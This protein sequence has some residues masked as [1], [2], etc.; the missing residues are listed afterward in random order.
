MTAAR[1]PPREPRPNAMAGRTVFVVLIALGLGLL[2]LKYGFDDSSSGSSS[3]A[4]TTTSSSTTVAD[5]STTTTIDLTTTQVLVAN[6]SGVSG[7]AARVSAGLKDKGYNVLPPT[8]A[9]Q[10]GLPTS[11]VYYQPGYEAQA[12]Q[13][14][15]SLGATT[16]AAM[17]SPP[18][19]AALG[20]ADVLVV[21]GKDLAGTPTG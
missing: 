20:E 5:A 21:V 1:R 11:T 6:G 18:P 16:T 12:G 7:A 14:A 15:Q 4:T 13:V 10:T 8:N 9:K 3:G 2:I 17:T 19:V